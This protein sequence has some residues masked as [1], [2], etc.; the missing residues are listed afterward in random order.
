MRARIHIVD[1]G[2][3]V[4][5]TKVY[6]DNKLILEGRG[7]TPYQVLQALSSVLEFDLEPMRVY[8]RQIIYEE[9]LDGV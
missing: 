2:N 5:W 8:G 9:V 3:V 4:D 6:I 7:L 1:D